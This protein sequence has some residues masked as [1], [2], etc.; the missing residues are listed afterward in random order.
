MYLA[1]R[2]VRT[3]RRLSLTFSRHCCPAFGAF[4]HV[5]AKLAAP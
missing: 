1:A 2:F 5:Y 3:G 4:H